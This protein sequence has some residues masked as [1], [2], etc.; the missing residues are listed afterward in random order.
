MAA[1]FELI[2]RGLG[3]LGV[4][5][6]SGRPVCGKRLGD[7][8]WQPSTGASASARV[9]GWTRAQGRPHGCAPAWAGE[10]EDQQGPF[11]GESKG[12]GTGGLCWAALFG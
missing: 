4:V 2:A 3:F 9:R 10:E 12:K 1:A 6:T 7:A 11:G 8:M 5:P